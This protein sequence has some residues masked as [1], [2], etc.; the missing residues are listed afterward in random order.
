MSRY[1]DE[2]DIRRT[3]RALRA[4]GWT[5][6]H[7]YYGDP[8]DCPTPTT[9]RAAIEDIMAVDEAALWV[10]RG[11]ESGYAFF[12]MGNGPGEVL[13]DYTVNLTILDTLEFEED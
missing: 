6:D 13:C 12:V 8:N 3:I 2:R 5:L 10:K 9:E 1:T 11:H 7:V 4:D